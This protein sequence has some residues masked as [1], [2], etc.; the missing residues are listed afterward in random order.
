MSKVP[1]PFA[2][3]GLA[4]LINASGTET[5]FGASPVG[6]EVIS[7]IGAILAHSVDMGELQAVASHVIARVTGGEAGFVTG[8]T[9]ASIAIAAAACMT[10]LDLGRIERLPD[11]TGLRNEVVIQKGHVVNYGS[12]ISGD[13]RLS[14]ARVIE[15]GA[16]AEAGAYQ[17]NA[18]IS[19]NTAA[20]VFV[21]SHHCVA[22]GMIR[23]AEFAI[24][25][26]EVGV[27]V[28]VDAA[29][30]YDWSGI[31]SAGA[32]LLLFSAQKALGG[33]TA[34]IIAGRRD[35]VRACYAQQRGI[36]RPMKAGKEAVMGVISALE[37]WESLD[38]ARIETLVEEKAQVAK[39]RLAS[40]PGL[41]VRVTRDETGNPFSRVVLTVAPDRAGLT[42]Y[43]LAAALAAGSPRVLLRN[44]YA[45][46]GVLQMDVR[47]LDEPTLDLVCDRIIATLKERRDGSDSMPTPADRAAEAVLGWLGERHDA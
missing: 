46:Q 32:D 5:I 18:A 23:L 45:D 17:L 26:H 30:E 19:A 38:H 25:C 47:R 9:S 15:V 29:A 10:G 22:T 3:Y 6:P 14:G 11:T 7:A 2:R 8:C 1:D 20:A 16:A 35:L 37:R 13:L 42:A 36:G 12:S 4:R 31:L 33:P 39:S 40:I 43:A 34:G 41:D 24:A 44:L 21:I 28:I 27:P